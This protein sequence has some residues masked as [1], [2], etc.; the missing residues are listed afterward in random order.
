LLPQDIV[1]PCVEELKTARRRFSLTVIINLLRKLVLFSN[2]SESQ[3]EKV[4]GMCRKIAVYPGQTLF[5]EK[6]GAYHIPVTGS[7]PRSV[8]HCWERFKARMEW[9]GADE[10]L[11]STALIIPHITG[12]YHSK[13]A[14]MKSEL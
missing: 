12:S 9:F 14:N 4:A 6:A 5:T 10:I 7:R 11:G 8:I 2:L 1:N 13:T 3:L